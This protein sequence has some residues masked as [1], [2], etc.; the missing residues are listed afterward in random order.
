MRPALAGAG[1]PR[2][3]SAE[4]MSRKLLA[5]P[6]SISGSGGSKGMRFSSD[7]QGIGRHWFYWGCAGVPTL[8]DLARLTPN[9]LVRDQDGTGAFSD[10]LVTFEQ[11]LYVGAQGEMAC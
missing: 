3:H 10:S 6:A 2:A 9:F 8:C 1:S 5:A 4:S 7:P 11:I